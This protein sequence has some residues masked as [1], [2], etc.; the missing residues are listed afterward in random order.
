MAKKHVN[1]GRR[2]TQSNRANRANQL[3]PN[4]DAYWKSRGRDG[5]PID[6]NNA[7]SK[8]KK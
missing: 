2:N 6:R 3:N 5:K 4:N 7:P 1:N 8:R